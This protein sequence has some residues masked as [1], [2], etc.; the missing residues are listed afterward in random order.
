MEHT[1]EHTVEHAVRPRRRACCQICRRP[2]HSATP[3]GH[4]IRPRHSATSFGHA[5]AHAIGRVNARAIQLCHRACCRTCRRAYR[6]AC[7][8]SAYIERHAS[9]STHRM[10]CAERH[11]PTGM[12]R[13]THIERHVSSGMCQ[14]ACVEQRVLNGMRRAACAGQH[15]PSG[16]LLTL[17]IIHCAD[18]MPYFGLESS[19]FRGF[20]RLV[21][22]SKPTSL[23][24]TTASSFR[25]PPPISSITSPRLHI[26]IHLMTRA[27]QAHAHLP[28]TCACACILGL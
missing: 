1:A 10:A 19:S 12:H 14:L 22:S 5:V 4:A 3:F 7:H 25:I 18:D 13:A 20:L 9:S 6:P 17:S 16:M 8:C 28:S 24:C 11:T 2:R 15:T 26:P 23:S 27:C 21:A